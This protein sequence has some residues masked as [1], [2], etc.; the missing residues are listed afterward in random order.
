MM[1]VTV[2]HY[3]ISQAIHTNWSTDVMILYVEFHWWNWCGLCLFVFRMG[4]VVS[5]EQRIIGHTQGTKQ[6][7]REGGREVEGI[8]LIEANV[9]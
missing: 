4:I 2:T 3:M 9:V 8:K 7:K 1:S 6:T 5:G